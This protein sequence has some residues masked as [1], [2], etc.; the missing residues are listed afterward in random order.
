MSLLRGQCRSRQSLLDSRLGR[1]R[2]VHLR[3]VAAGRQLPLSGLGRP[4]PLSRVVASQSLVD[5]SCQLGQA[6]PW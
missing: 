5:G 2:S 6:P 4:V 1:M 3:N